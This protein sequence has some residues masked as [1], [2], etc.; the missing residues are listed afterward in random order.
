MSPASTTPNHESN[1]LISTP[2]SPCVYLF[3]VLQR[4]FGSIKGNTKYQMPHNFF[5]ILT[6]HHLC[7]RK[8]PSKSRLFYFHP[9][10]RDL[11]YDMIWALPLKS[12]L[13]TFKWFKT[14]FLEILRKKWGYTKFA[15]MG[16]NSTIALLVRARCDI[17]FFSVKKPHNFL[18]IL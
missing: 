14:Q 8:L 3:F 2:V 11:S 15:Q 13:Q 12:G 16:T 4:I 18:K 10:K 9:K 5:A 1:H 17:Y 6:Y 7:H